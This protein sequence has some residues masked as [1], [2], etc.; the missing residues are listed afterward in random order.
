MRTDGEFNLLIDRKLV[1]VAYTNY[2]VALRDYCNEVIISCDMS[3]NLMRESLAHNL[4]FKICLVIG[5][6]CSLTDIFVSVL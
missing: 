1:Q 6:D 4:I 2:S 3:V 5:I